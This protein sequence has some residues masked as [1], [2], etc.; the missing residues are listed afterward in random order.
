MAW[1]LLLLFFPVGE[2]E[3]LQ[4]ISSDNCGN[5]F[6]FVFVRL[7]FALN[8]ALFALVLVSEYPEVD[9]I[10]TALDK[11]LLDDCGK[12]TETRRPGVFALRTGVP[13]FSLDPVDLCAL[14]VGHSLDPSVVELIR[15]IELEFVSL[16]VR[17]D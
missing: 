14:W 1:F 4:S 8:L 11:F 7:S 5:S 12:L 16:N 9:R 2:A 3:T 10:A 13:N 17:C 15:M 6:H